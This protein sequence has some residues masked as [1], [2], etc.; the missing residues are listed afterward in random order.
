LQKRLDGKDAKIEKKDEEIKLLNQALIV[1]NEKRLDDATQHITAFIGLG[2]DL[3]NANT[4][5]QKSIDSLVRYN[6]LNGK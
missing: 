2:K 3:T 1:V 4:A 5:M 6:E